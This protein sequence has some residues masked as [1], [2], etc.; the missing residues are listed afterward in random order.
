M[1][2][3]SIMHQ[4]ALMKE[5][6]NYKDFASVEIILYLKDLNIGMFNLYNIQLFLSADLLVFNTTYRLV[7]C[8][9]NSITFCDSKREFK[10]G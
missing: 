10:K 1:K 2:T 7:I 6:Y 5:Y 8:D 3:Y 4:I 9:K